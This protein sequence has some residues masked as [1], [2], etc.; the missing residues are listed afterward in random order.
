MVRHGRKHDRTGGAPLRLALVVGLLLA[1][2][3]AEGQVVVVG[4]Q[5]TGGMTGT[6]IDART[7]SPLSYALLRLPALGVERFA[8]EAGAFD[9]GGIPSAP[10]QVAITQP[11]YVP[12]DTVIWVDTTHSV[13]PPFRLEPVR[14]DVAMIPVTESPRCFAPQEADDEARPGFAEL[15][16]QMMHNAERYRVLSSSYSFAATYER[17]W[18]D[19]AANGSTSVVDTDS[20]TFRSIDAPRYRAG[21]VARLAPRAAREQD[22]AIRIPTIMDVASP[23]FRRFH[24]FSFGGY[25]EFAG[26]TL[27]RIDFTVAEWVSTPDVNGAVYVDPLN[28]Q[29]RGMRASLT[30]IPIRGIDSLTV[31]TL[32]R[33]MAP[34]LLVPTQISSATYYR[35]SRGI[36][37]PTALVA[38]TETQWLIDMG[39]LGRAPGSLLAASPSEARP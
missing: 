34:S 21:E 3:P 19:H 4:R 30:R 32:Y 39:F 38:R 6:V 15:V 31:T 33:E 14:I 26:E 18:S 16:E 11:G 17:V 29:V 1:A 35:P 23:E 27:A 22:W 10:H 2:P 20:S 24:C 5:P 37:E 8:D 9:L 28:F 7:G 12:R 25:D 36:H 13:Q